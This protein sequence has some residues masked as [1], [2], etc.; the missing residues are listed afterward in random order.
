MIF[1]YRIYK[2]KKRAFT[3]YETILILLIITTILN[4]TF[5]KYID[6]QEKQAINQAM[7]KINEAFLYASTK[8]L[9][10]RKSYTLKFEPKKIIIQNNI[11]IAEKE[12]H[13]PNN[14]YYYNTLKNNEILTKYSLNLYFTK[15]GNI[16]QSFSIYILDRK[17]YAR[18]KISFYG[19]DR[20]RFLIINN[21]RKKK[22][23]KIPEKL[24]FKYHKE[25]NEDR[26]AF[27]K[28]WRK[29]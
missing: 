24:L 23:T 22:E 13:L 8:S 9:N 19:F 5:L 14:I 6:F 18:Y 11:G 29:E 17:R 25:T 26:P 1:I 16:S 3:F 21:Y 2:Y 12:Y 27:Y 28:D 20:S 7:L 15:N 10:N 4:F